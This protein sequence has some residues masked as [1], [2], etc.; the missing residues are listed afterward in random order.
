M[1]SAAKLRLVTSVFWIVS[2]GKIAA[3]H[4]SPIGTNAT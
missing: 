1:K 4:M 3:L 2:K